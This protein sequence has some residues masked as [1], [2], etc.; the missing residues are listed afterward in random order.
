LGLIAEHRLEGIGRPLDL[1]RLRLR[2]DL[3]EHHDHDTCPQRPA[4]AA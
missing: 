1:A 3:E 2:Y 4:G